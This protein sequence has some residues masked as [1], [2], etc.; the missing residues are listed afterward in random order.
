MEIKPAEN[1]PI[2]NMLVKK[3]K[4]QDNPMEIPV[5]EYDSKD[6][7]ALEEFCK[8]HGIFGFNFGRMHPRAALSMLRSKMGLPPI[9]NEVTPQQVK[10]LIKG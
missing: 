7:K 8:S 1:D 10:Q 9:H 5:M 6:I 3:R 2:F 4:Q